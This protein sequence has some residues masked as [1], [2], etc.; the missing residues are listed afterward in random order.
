MKCSN[1]GQELED[2]IK[3][4]TNCGSPI[5]QPKKFHNATINEV[6]ISTTSIIQGYRIIRYCNPISATAV[7][8][9]AKRSGLFEAIDAFTEAKI[10]RASCRER[11]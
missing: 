2:G 7:Q 5:K 11:V 1:C 6:L 4:C 9:A 10:V 3:F 8:I